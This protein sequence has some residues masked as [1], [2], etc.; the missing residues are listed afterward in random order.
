MAD[1][2]AWLC[3][4]LNLVLILAICIPIFIFASPIMSI[5]TPS[6]EVIE[7]GRTTLRLAAGFEMFFSTF[8]VI[9]GICRGSA[10]V[11]MPLVVSTVGVW[12]VR[13]E[14]AYLFG[15]ILHGGLVGV[16]AGISFDVVFRGVMMLIR[17]KSRKWMSP[18][19][20]SIE[21][22]RNIKNIRKTGKAS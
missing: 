5:F 2:F 14:L 6:A 13:L 10:D 17:L 18:S 11:K 9:S 7:L 8:V 19:S 4:K 20:L 16:W 12:V 22:I 1:K 21:N 3:V 15:V